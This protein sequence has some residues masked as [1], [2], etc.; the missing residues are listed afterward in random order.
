MLTVIGLP[1]LVY[2]FAEAAPIAAAAGAL[3]L[4]VFVVTALRSPAP[5]LDLRLFRDR[6]FSSAAAVV[7]GMGVALLTGS[8]DYW[9]LSAVQVVRGC[10]IGLTT[11]P[12]LAT[13]LVS[14]PKE[15]IS[16]AMP[17]FAMLQRIGGSFGTSALTAV[18]AARLAAAPGAAPKCPQR[19]DQ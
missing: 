15:R 16:H 19:T 9:W 11:T 13:G 8:D 3:L 12:A 6:T 1:L 10:G 14:V 17:L 7:F 18:V 4:A 5:L 2:G